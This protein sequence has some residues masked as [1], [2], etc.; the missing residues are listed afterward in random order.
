MKVEIDRRPYV[1]NRFI[2]RS[3]PIS[4]ECGRY[5]AWPD[6]SNEYKSYL[7]GLIFYKYLSDNILQA[8]CDSL[9]ETFESFQQAQLFY[10]EN[11][12]DADVREDLIEVL[13]DEL[14]YVI[15]PSLTFTKLVQS[16][17]E[18]TFQLESLAQSFRDI[19]QANE[20]FKNLF[21]DIDLYAKK[22]GKYPTKTKQDHL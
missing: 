18:G 6:V 13:N 10:E 15:E 14:G 9:D 5:P 20:K 12:T 22:L 21:E 16:I 8:V 19:E 1:T 2:K 7:F 3:L 11:F 17:H 4:L